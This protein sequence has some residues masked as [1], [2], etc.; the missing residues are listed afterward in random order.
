MS[1]IVRSSDISGLKKHITGKVRDVYDLGDSLLLVASDRLSAFDVVLP[2]GIPDKGRVLTQLS[3]F[4]FDMTRNIVENH[5]ITADA[6]EIIEHMKKAGVED[7]EDYRDSIEGR[8]ILGKKAEQ[9]P[10][11]CVVRGYLSGSAWKEYKEL[12][13]NAKDTDTVTLHGVTLPTT[14]VESDRLPEPVF[15]PATK[16]SS[17]H[18]INISAEQARDVV[19]KELVD[20]LER[21]SLAIYNKASDY[22]RTRGIIISDTKFEF[23]LRD[24]KIILIDE[25]LTP[26]SSRFWA[27][28]DYE[29]GR[30]QAAFDKQFVRDYLETL[31]WDKTYP[32]PTL[33]PDIVEK[34]SE[35]Y[36]EAYRRIVGKELA[37]GL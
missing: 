14:L 15:T 20:E 21:L 12:L 29:P 6:D 37:R 30:P 11:E 32:G 5:V 26:D 36:R 19:G 2:G 10:I 23:G 3:L 22:A 9:I 7:A 31:D 33:P 27:V 4:W 1:T 18:D 17:G 28:A 34:T 24:G 16:E 13:A 25:I 35:R 8:T